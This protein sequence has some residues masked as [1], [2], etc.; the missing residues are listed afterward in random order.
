LKRKN[1]LIL[2]LGVIVVLAIL[3]LFSIY[4]KNY[5]DDSSY[6]QAPL[7]NNAQNY[8]ADNVQKEQPVDSQSPKFPTEEIKQKPSSISDTLSETPSSISTT[9]VSAP[10]SQQSSDSSTLLPGR[11]KQGYTDIYRCSGNK[12]LRETIDTYCKQAWQAWKTCDYGCANSTCIEPD[13]ITL[14]SSGFTDRYQCESQES[15]REY[16]NK[17]CK[18]SWLKDQLCLYGCNQATGKCNSAS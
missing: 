3:F 4:S 11:C 2:L 10:A 1:N 12:I 18:T 14:C 17:A 15:Q 13:G 5:S 7:D 6:E 8:Q 9:A 16:K